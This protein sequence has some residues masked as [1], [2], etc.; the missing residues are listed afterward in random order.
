MKATIQYS[1][2][3]GEIPFKI[4]E[5][6]GECLSQLKMLNSL[7]SSLGVSVPDLFISRIDSLRLKMVDIDSKLEECSVLMQG[8]VEAS[9]KLEEFDQASQEDIL[10]DEET[11]LDSP[12]F[13]LNEALADIKSLSL[14]DPSEWINKGRDE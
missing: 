10:A 14:P 1:V 7:A 3:L 6:Y 2:E 8:Y 13:N 11:D 9:R 5:L 12:D 4:E